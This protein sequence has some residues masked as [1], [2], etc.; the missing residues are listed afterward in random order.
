MCN[1]GEDLTVS[2]KGCFAYKEEKTHPKRTT[3]L[4]RLQQ[5]STKLVTLSHMYKWL[6]LNVK[7]KRNHR[8][9]N[10]Q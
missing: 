7:I 5:K 9:K 3:A 1:Y 6:V 10:Y 2:W 8:L 4:Q